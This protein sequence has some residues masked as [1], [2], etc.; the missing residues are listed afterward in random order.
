MESPKLLTAESILI[1]TDKGAEEISTRAY[2][3]PAKLR[4]T[5]IMIDGESSIGDIL[6]KCGEFADRVEQQLFDLLDSGFVA[7]ARADEAHEAE[8]ISRTPRD[9]RNF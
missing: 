9:L 5:L 2:H 8:E 6:E 1:K 3:L 7:E 4:A